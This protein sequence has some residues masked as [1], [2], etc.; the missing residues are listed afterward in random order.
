MDQLTV[1]VSDRERRF[2]LSVPELSLQ[3]GDVIGLSGPSGSGKTMMLEVLGL[4]RRPTKCGA[5]RIDTEPSPIDLTRIWTR[6]DISPAQ[7]RADLF[8]F[9]PQSGGLLPFMTVAD[10]IALSQRISEREDADWVTELT[11][12]LRLSDVTGLHPGALSIGQRQRVAIARALAHRPA[13]VIADEPTAALD[14]GAAETAMGLMIEVAKSGG[15]AV[16]ISSH[17][18]TLLDR[19][20][21]TRLGLAVSSDN[22]GEVESRLGALELTA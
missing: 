22:S 14:P 1:S 5:F 7:I 3:S 2:N 17:D 13:F 9:V 11:E 12:R 19:F 10:N 18:L 6:G 8:G 16:I 20:A 21:M 4:L 15:A